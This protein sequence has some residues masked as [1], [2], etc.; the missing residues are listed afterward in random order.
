MK[1][2]LTLSLAL[3][4]ISLSAQS[5]EPVDT[6]AIAKIREHGLQ[7]SQV[8]D[9]MFWLTD[10]YG[11]RLTGSKEFEEAGDWAVKQLQSWGVETVRK[12]RFPFGRGWSLVKFHA[13]M[14]EPRVMPI[15]GLPKAWST[16]TNGMF[17][18]DVVR[19][20]ITNAQE[21]E[22]WRGK[23]RGKIVLTQPAREV[24][25][26][27][28]PIVLRYGDNSK[29]LEEALSVPPARGGGAGR[30]AG[31][32]AG[33]DTGAGAGRAVGAGGAGRA[34]GAGVVGPAGRAGGAGGGRAGGGAGA[35]NVNTF[36]R[37]EGVLAL[38][39]RGS[40]SDMSAGGSDLSWQTQRVDGGTVFVQSGGSAA[41]DPATI[42]P[43]VTL[44]VE[45]YNRMVRLLEHN[46]PVKVELNIEVATRAED[47]Q[48]PN[49][50]NVVGEIRGTDKADEIV[51]IGAHFDSWHGATGAT[52]N[53]AGSAAMMEVLRIFK[54]AGLRPRRT[55]RIGLWGAEENG[56][57][58][59]QAYVREHLGTREAPKPELAKMSAYFNIDNGTGRI[60]GIWMQGNTAVKPI[61]EAW[62]RP[63]K[64]LG[65]DIL[66]PR[67][68]TSTDHTR[69]DAVG[70]PAFQFVQE[71]YE[72][73][74]RTHHSN[75][76]FYDRVQVEDM[77]Q[78][79][80][81][82]AI[83]VWHAATRETLLPRK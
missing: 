33:S 42:L 59:S 50:F 41:A 45:H 55:V 38:F 39:D 8:M 82:A 36:Y 29:W 58:G 21:A 26:L 60:R 23:L 74:S 48:T 68:V 12:E 28:G 64:D 70:V 2:V 5:T 83:F 6:A 47:A 27:E 31:A 19:P 56:L 17:T 7:K 13:Q 34:A 63:L 80:T 76:D 51:L 65:V 20:Q 1:R 81:V 62:T 32:A 11:P 3:L 37:E 18:A 40:N 77:K 53:A 75:M 71:R 54:A 57:I 4:T 44:A 78:M 22:S 10:R 14:T 15:I 72:Y 52:D 24:R 35:F 69:F 73:N 46:T 25:M 43:Q 67:S 66:G 30:A 79:A 9:T 61:F 16:G 49:G